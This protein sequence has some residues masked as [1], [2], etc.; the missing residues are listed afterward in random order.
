MNEMVIRRDSEPK[1]RAR[2]RAAGR[3]ARLRGSC[4]AVLGLCALA[5]CGA[6]ATQS[7]AF[8]PAVSPERAAE[9]LAAVDAD[10]GCAE[11][12]AAEFERG[13]AGSRCDHIREP[14][15]ARLDRMEPK[16]RFGWLEQRKID[17]RRLR[18]I[19]GEA[20]RCRTWPLLEPGE[21]VLWGKQV[22]EARCNRQRFEGALPVVGVTAAG[23]RV[24]AFEA[25]IANG[26]FE[27]D[28]ARLDRR[29]R[30]EGHG[31]LDAFDRL[32]LGTGAW[33]GTVDLVR[34]RQFLADW[35]YRWVQM[36][37]G[38]PGLFVARNPEHVS[39][40]SGR[41]LATE[42]RLA[43]QEHD[44]LAVAS[45]DLSPLAFLDRHLW[46]PYRSSVRSIRYARS[47]HPA[48]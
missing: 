7:R 45:G 32:E 29:L 25:E 27:L 16:A 44:Y 48:P 47:R 42:A 43:R 20:R 11:T 5:A 36:G 23:E 17:L 14:A 8:G 10:A 15:R 40:D 46:S 26:V 38:V 33:A 37:R 35:H 12:L 30:L 41:A 21:T 6:K 34:L 22:R 3:T 2:L 4:L 18:L 39:A 9:A 31:G 28:Y 13:V 24:P 19:L 1:G